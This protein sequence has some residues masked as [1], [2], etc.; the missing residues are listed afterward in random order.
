MHASESAS[1][2][3]DLLR[4]LRMRDPVARKTI[5]ENVRTGATTNRFALGSRS[6]TGRSQSS[7]C[8]L[9]V[10]FARSTLAPMIGI[11][12]AVASFAYGEWAG[13][14]SRLRRSGVEHDVG[15]DKELA[16]L[17]AQ[18]PARESSHGRPRP[19]GLRRF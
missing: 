7:S 11:P 15:S 17:F 3:T 4:A 2:A 5:G 13:L 6:A 9:I 14:R 10:S 19:R 18:R 12:L 16:R 1:V 8:N